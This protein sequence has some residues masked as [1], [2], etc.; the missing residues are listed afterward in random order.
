MPES[1][2]LDWEAILTPKLDDFASAHRPW[3]AE[4]CVKRRADATVDRLPAVGAVFGTYRTMLEA[5][6]AAEPAAPAA[7]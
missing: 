3:L 4:A 6:T 1:V 5:L 2:S 7:R